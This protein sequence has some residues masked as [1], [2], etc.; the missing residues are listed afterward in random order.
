MSTKHTKDPWTY[1]V[2]SGF[3]R[4]RDHDVIC[5]FWSKS[6]EDFDN[7]DANAKLIA[8]A[9]DLLEALRGIIARCDAGLELT[10]GDYKKAA[11]AIEKA[12][13]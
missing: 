11:S 12:T 4:G 6:E 1:D 10:L 7:G 13:T 8:A 2:R 9:P 5:Q 3:V